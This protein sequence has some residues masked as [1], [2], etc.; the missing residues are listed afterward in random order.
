MST[1]ASSGATSKVV[2]YVSW[3]SD[4]NKDERGKNKVFVSSNMSFMVL[5]NR[6]SLKF[7]DELLFNNIISKCE[8]LEIESI[9]I[10]WLMKEDW[11]TNETKDQ[12][13]A[14]KVEVFSQF[15]ASDN[16]AWSVAL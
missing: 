16:H 11:K 1:S 8:V 13:E 7:F 10:C 14:T 12:S 9:T 3:Y 5:E 2:L 6:Y 4:C 15:T